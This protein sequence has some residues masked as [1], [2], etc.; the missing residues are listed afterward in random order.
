MKILQ[1]NKYYYLKG[2]AETVFL[3]TLQLLEKHGHTVIPFCLKSRKNYPTPYG[4]YFVDYP[5]L[6]ESGFF[7]KLRHLFSFIH[8][9]KAARQLE[10]LLRKEKPDLAHIHLLFNSFS[11]SILPV[12]K[13]YNVPVVMTVHDY[14]LICPAYTFTN[15]KGAICERCLKS[16]S[17]WR[18]ITGRCSKNNLPNS[19]LLAADSYYR[20][21]FHQPVELID[22]FIFVSRFSQNKHIE[23]CRQYLPK[24]TLLY[25]FTLL[26]DNAATPAKEAYILYFGRISEEKGIATLMEAAREAGIPLKVAGAGPLLE[27]FGK[28]GGAKV[29]FLGFQSGD[30]LKQLILKANFVAVPSEWYE[31]NPLSIIE[32]MALGT[33][34]IG[35]RIGGIPELIRDGETGFLFEAKSSA[36]LQNA[37][38][39]ALSLS[40][41]QYS[42]MCAQA[43]RFARENF[44]ENTHYGKLLDI[45]NKTLQ[46]A[47]E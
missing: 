16:R 23:A 8:N 12:L 27:Q 40:P 24:S 45:Y 38:R 4:E 11:V 19:I 5:E 33:P 41:A 17:F 42:E 6:S 13:K 44:S 46:A 35:S 14:R 32:S 26:E 29:E 3:N 25:N 28:Q 2:G 22:K 7:T 31:N 1:I 20:K 37:L 10:R 9:R 39:K 36:S 18:C 43:R 34:V 47:R 21:Y 15:G 30:A